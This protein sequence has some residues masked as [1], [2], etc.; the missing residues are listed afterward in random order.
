MWPEKR[1]MAR[2][3]H[4]STT[5]LWAKRPSFA[6]NGRNGGKSKVSGT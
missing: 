5:I 2:L 1:K 4:N 3:R 6:K